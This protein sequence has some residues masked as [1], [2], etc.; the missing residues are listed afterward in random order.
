[1]VFSSVIFLCFFLPAFLI[2]YSS[3]P[4]Q[5]KNSWIL[6]ASLAFYTWGAPKFVFVLLISSL[7]DYGLTQHSEFRTK[8]LLVSL[9]IAVNLLT[10][11]IFK[12]FNFFIENVE[13]V[14]QSLGFGFPDFMEIALPIGISFFTFQKIS[15]LIDAYRGDAE[16]AKKLQ[17]YLLFVCLFP[18]LIAGPIIRYKDI[19]GQIQNRFDHDSWANRISGFNRFVIGLSKKVLIADVLA[20]VADSA[21]ESAEFSTT[22]AWL[23]LLA[24]TFQIYFDFSG[25]SDMA[26]GLGQLMGFRFPENFNWPYLAS[27]FRDFWQRWHITLSIW[28]RDYLYVPMGGNKVNGI[29]TMRNLW[30]VFLFS[31]F[32]HGASWNFLLW[33]AWHGLFISLDRFSGLFRAV[34]KVISILLTFFLVMIGWVFFRAEDLGH[35]IAYLEALYSFQTASELT[36]TSRQGFTLFLALAFSFTP[37]LDHKYLLSWF[38]SV[39]RLLVLKMIASLILLGLCLGTLALADGQPFIYFRF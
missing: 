14:F 28:M 1:M 35:S 39:Q 7:L 36:I 23:G 19:E 4:R 16:P 29:V 38:D 21:F 37:F 32:W 17:D 25:Y 5:W 6:F 26:I 24:Y 20:I 11:V 33:G 22:Q 27:G 34:P 31:G 13:S 18:Q 9:G 8:K 30:I 10:L 15:Y 2:V 12:Y 3:L